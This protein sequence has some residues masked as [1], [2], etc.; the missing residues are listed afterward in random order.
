MALF[1]DGGISTTDD[2]I[3]QDSALLDVSATE[4][5][6]LSQKLLL[7][8]NEV[9]IELES[10]FERT[11][12]IYTFGTGYSA[13]DIA[14]VV[15][16]LPLK[17][18]H[19]YQTL[20]CI[21]R[22]AYFSQ[23]N[24][25][26]QGKWRAFEKLARNAMEQVVEQGV[27]LVLDPVPQA[28]APVLTVQPGIQ[29]GGDFYAAASYVNA[30]G[31]EGLPSVVTDLTVAD[32]NDLVVT[33]GAAPLSAVGWNVYVGADPQHLTLQNYVPLPVGQP[34]VWQLHSTGGKAPGQGQMPNRMRALPRRWQRG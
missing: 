20:A 23:L 33:P 27:G 30:S 2:L 24:E 13:L 28:P 7:A 16:T 10:C 25:R 9:R 4:N 5:I 29:N 22:D 34:F 1:C 17:L 26:Y 6:D 18:W 8:Q 31:E 15:V 19:T 3:A 32:G 14:N 21:Y 12:T 11:R